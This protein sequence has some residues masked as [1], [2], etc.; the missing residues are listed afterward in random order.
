MGRGQSSIKKTQT[1][2]SFA[3]TPKIKTDVIGRLVFNGQV[4][5]SGHTVEYS[6]DYN[7]DGSSVDSFFRNNSNSESLINGM[8]S[9]EQSDFKRWGKGDF[10]K[11]Q[12]Y[13]GF[14][15]M[16]AKDQ[17]AT[18]TFDKYLDQSVL[19]DGVQVVR[20]SDAQLVLG[21]GNAKPSLS[22]L[23]AAEGSVVMSKGNMSFSAAS[24][25]LK[26]DMMSDVNVEYKL[27]IPSGTRGAGMY[28]G[29]KKINK[30]GNRQ[31]EFMTNRDTA[32]RVGKTSFD[33]TR[34]VFVVE[35]QYEG[36][37]AHDYS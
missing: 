24:K 9:A 31:R 8:N 27:S 32:Y 33:A 20:L 25:G 18:K 29:N 30:W 13:N 1:F 7:D 5:N 19:K 34:N 36:R 28:I 35:L 4:I 37:M 10:M 3:D 6:M 12:Q 14:S 15:K 2:H 22:A 23:Q 11:G 26:I 17:A 21:K 16:N